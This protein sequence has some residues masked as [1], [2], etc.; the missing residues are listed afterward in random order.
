MSSMRNAA[1]SEGNFPGDRPA[2]GD[3][4][5]LRNLLNSD[6]RFHGVDYTESVP[7][8]Q[9][10][11]DR[12]LEPWRP[13]KVDLADLSEFRRAR[14]VVRRMVVERGGPAVA[15]FNELAASY[16]LLCELSPDATESVV[17]PAVDVTPVSL[18]ARMV[19]A[20]HQAVSTGEWP[21]LRACERDDCGW[22]YFDAS[23]SKRGRWCT[24]SCGSVM[25]TRAYRERTRLHKV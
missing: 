1:T 4:E 22:I 12:Y 18:C 17:R 15:E 24:L 11:L 7:S 2:T 23:P 13:A 19:A 9:A 25:K 5:L 10:Y 20:V 21:Y 8:F 6:D 3:L 14:D 16:P